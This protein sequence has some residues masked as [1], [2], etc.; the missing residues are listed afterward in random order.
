M[1]AS[2]S[3]AELLSFTKASVRFP[4]AVAGALAANTRDVGEVREARTS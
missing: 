4:V 3:P 2:A 1:E